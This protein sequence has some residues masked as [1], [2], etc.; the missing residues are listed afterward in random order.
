MRSSRGRGVNISS[1]SNTTTMARLYSY[2][3]ERRVE[4]FRDMQQVWGP[5]AFDPYPLDVRRLGP[6]SSG[7]IFLTLT[8]DEPGESDIVGTSQQTPSFHTYSVT[9]RR[10]D[11]SVPPSL[12]KRRDAT[13]IDCRLTHCIVSCLSVCHQSVDGLGVTSFGQ[14]FLSRGHL[15]TCGEF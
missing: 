12:A 13:Y 14:N 9:C 11:P 8:N 5:Q 15:L 10:I 6:T 2:G 7:N 1:S 3:P 4:P